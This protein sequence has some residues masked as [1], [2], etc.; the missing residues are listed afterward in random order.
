LIDELALFTLLHGNI[1]KFSGLCVPGFA[2]LL[3][4]KNL[5]SSRLKRLL[6]NIQQRERE[7]ALALRR[8]L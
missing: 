8:P 5:Q 4:A 1:E 3:N 6:L 7:A 2:I